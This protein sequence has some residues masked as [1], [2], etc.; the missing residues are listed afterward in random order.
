MRSTYSSRSSL[1]LEFKVRDAFVKVIE[2][3]PENRNRGEIS[4]KFGPENSYQMY[5]RDNFKQS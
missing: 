3:S 1:P 2:P 4:I 5:Q